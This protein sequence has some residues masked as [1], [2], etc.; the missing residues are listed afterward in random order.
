ME[1]TALI[2]ELPEMLVAP[3]VTPAFSFEATPTPPGLLA[4]E[5]RWRSWTTRHR[6]SPELRSTSLL[7][8]SLRA[9]CLDK[10]FATVAFTAETSFLGEIAQIWVVPVDTRPTERVGDFEELFR[11]TPPAP[12]SPAERA[13]A[14]VSDVQAWLG[15]GRDDV[16]QLAGYS[17]RSIKNWR[18][19]M[20]PYPA[21]VRRLFDIHALVGAL[22]RQMGSDG[23][24]VWLADAAADGRARRD[25]LG[26]EAGL[27]ALVSEAAAV[28][29]EP[30]VR[31]AR[32]VELE[33]PAHPEIQPRPELF[34]GPVRRTRRRH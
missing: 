24:R 31:D 15:I 26:E 25:L 1:Q 18:E 16:A 19:G 12:P 21:T 28:L 3:D 33:E 23:A 29:F 14:A 2:A 11:P 22:E 32:T 6:W 27:R 17:P 10:W 5:D 13:L 20:D 30:P 4:S 9:A 8:A 34:A 7:P